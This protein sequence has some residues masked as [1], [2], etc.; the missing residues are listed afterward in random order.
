MT[1]DLIDPYA[2][3][4]RGLNDAAAARYLGLS[5]GAFTI[6]VQT[7]TL[8]RALY[9]GAASVW[10]REE[11]DAA[12]AK[13]PAEGQRAAKSARTPLMSQEWPGHHHVY[14]PSTL[15]ERWRC[16]S[17]LIRN[18]I[19]RGELP[20]FKYGGKLVRIRA[21]DVAAYENSKAGEAPVER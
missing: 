5:Q 9:L 13:L 19:K 15:A 14:T 4:P 17:Q 3:P 6:L 11:L 8:P 7:G 20:S 12:F 2:Y 16:S 10:D 21:A 18:M 1:T